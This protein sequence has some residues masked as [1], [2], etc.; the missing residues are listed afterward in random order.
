MDLELLQRGELFAL[1]EVADGFSGWVIQ[2]ESEGTLIRLVL[3]EK[4]HGAM[5]DAFAQRWI[6]KQQLPLKLDRKV[7]MGWVSSHER[8]LMPANRFANRGLWKI[9]EIWGKSLEVRR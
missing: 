4:D 6:R 3:G 9:F 5:E 1:Q 2:D 8:I 7:G